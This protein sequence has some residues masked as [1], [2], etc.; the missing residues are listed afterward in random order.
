MIFAKQRALSI[1]LISGFGSLSIAK[2]AH[3]LSNDDRR[4]DFECEPAFK[5]ISK[6]MVSDSK[7]D[8]HY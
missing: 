4:Y 3:A 8:G 6:S 2:N 5:L 7:T 1:S